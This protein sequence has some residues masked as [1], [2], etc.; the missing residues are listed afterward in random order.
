MVGGIVARYQE[1][2]GILIYALEFLGNH[3]HMLIRAPQ[4][5]SDE[6]CENVNREIAKRINALLGREG[7]FWGRRY[8]DQE[9]LS[10]EDLLEAFLYISTNAT[11][12]GLIA[13]PSQWKG[14]NSFSQSITGETETFSFT[15]YSG[16]GEPIV[17]NHKLTISPLPQ[18]AGFS[19]KKRSRLVRR[20]LNERVK[21]LVLARNGEFA[22]PDALEKQTPGNVPQSVSRSARPLCYTQNSS[23]RRAFKERYRER[24][25]C[26]DR[27]SMRYRLGDR[28]VRFPE[29]SFKPPLHRRPRLT[30]FKPLSPSDLKIAA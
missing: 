30:P 8:D 26:Y 14:L 20:L 7:K 17:T 16:A 15:R 27:A 1:I 29:H 6:F 22:R 18:H 11:K 5:N 10:E 13:D 3:Y 25:L 24:R 19:R 12:H 2:F 28:D 23:L 21:A 4:G 9:I